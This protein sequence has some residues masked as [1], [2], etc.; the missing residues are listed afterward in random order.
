MLKSSQVSYFA[1]FALLTVAARTLGAERTTMPAADRAGAVEIKP[2]AISLNSPLTE[3]ERSCVLRRRGGMNILA[4]ESSDPAITVAWQ[5]GSA[6][7][8]FVVTASLPGGY[9]HPGR[10]R[11][12]IR[13]H[14][15]L[16]DQPIVRIPVR[17]WSRPVSLDEGWLRAARTWI[18]HPAPAMAAWRQDGRRFAIA[19]RPGEVTAIVFSAHWCGHCDDRMPVIEKVSKEFAGRG[20]RF[21]GIN[22]ADGNGVGIAQ[23]MERWGIDWTIGLD[24]GRELASQFGI[25]AYPVILLIGRDGVIE[26]VHGRYNNYARTNGLQDIEAELRTELNILLAGG[27]RADFPPAAPARQAA[28]TQPAARRPVSAG[29]ASRPASG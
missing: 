24:R 20:V 21:Y 18:G 3:T 4:V 9:T 19:A 22:V 5:E 8:T 12:E 26:A 25:V 2:G 14:T 11:E 1:A 13:V 10:D 27:T 29:V 7:G 15:D 23:A 17:V 6:P 16:P 28:T